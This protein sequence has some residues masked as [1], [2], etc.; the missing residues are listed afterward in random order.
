MT[1][2]STAR[3]PAASKAA[4][5]STE[6]APTETV[7]KLG[8]AQLVNLMVAANTLTE[9]DAGVAVD[10]VLEIVVE[11][12]KTGK[13]VGLPGLGTLGVRDTPAR[14]GVRPGTSEKLQIPAGK[15]VT[16]KVASTLKS[17]F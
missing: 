4:A 5:K 12:L 8:K 3:K 9:R 17:A 11:A 2:K 10:A 13:S 6:V 7:E 16:F 14:Q 15:K 1:K